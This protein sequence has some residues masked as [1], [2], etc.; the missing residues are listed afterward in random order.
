MT[1]HD[2]Y[3]HGDLR[4]ALID[5]AMQMVEQEGIAG[6]TLRGA[7]RQAGVSHAAP[8]H[9]FQDKSALVAAIVVECFERF[10][11]A[12]QSA[13]DTTAGSALERYMAVG[14]AYV[15]FALG[16][17]ELFR[18]MSRPEMREFKLLT[19]PSSKPFESI[20]PDDVPAFRVLMQSIRACQ[21]E[22]VMVEGD[23]LPLALTSWALVHGL[24]VLLLDSGFQTP[25]LTHPLGA[26]A[27]ADIIIRQSV[28]GM[29][30]R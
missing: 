27:L 16:H 4:R 6:L 24:V 20:T 1:T 30:K 11:N 21:A 13:Y 29:G 23:P 5:A 25:F 14:R 26:D 10:E 9:H 17:P 19:L 7:A 28:V 22:G 3:H 2:E 15:R 12:L 18:L 8:Y